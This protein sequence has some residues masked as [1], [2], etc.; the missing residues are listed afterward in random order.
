MK[1]VMEIIGLNK[2]VIL[3]RVLIVGGSIAGLVIIGKMLTTKVNDE[4]GFEFEPMENSD[5]ITDISPGK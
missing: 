4:E 2:G 3:K 5:D 1:N